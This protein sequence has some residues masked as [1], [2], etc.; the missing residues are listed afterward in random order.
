MI[1]TRVWSLAS[2]SG[3]KIWRWRELWYRL[4]AWLGTGIAVAVV[5]TASDLAP[6]LGTSI[7]QGSDPKKQKKK[8][9]YIRLGVLCSTIGDGCLVRT[10]NRIPTYPEW[11]EGMILCGNNNWILYF[12]AT[13]TACVSSQARNQTRTTGA[14]R[15]ETVPT[16]DP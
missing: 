4:Q 1:L 6:S 13:P 7:W 12:L 11:Q 10:Q 9:I 2:L 5:S 14:T 15:A 16:P 8:K 3:L